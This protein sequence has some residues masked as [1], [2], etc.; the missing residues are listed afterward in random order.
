MEAMFIYGATKSI[1]RG[2]S[3]SK[4]VMWMKVFSCI[5]TAIYLALIAAGVVYLNMYGEMYSEKVIERT[6]GV[7]KLLA[8]PLISNFSYLAL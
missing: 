2:K 8:S 6:A 3:H 4:G 5:N 1:F 7:L